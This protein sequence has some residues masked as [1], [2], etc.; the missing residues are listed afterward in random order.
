MWPLPGSN[1]I[2][3]AHKLRAELD[4]L[5][6]TLP[7]HIDMQLAFDATKFMEDAL[8][9][10]SHTLAETILIVGLVV[11]L[12]VGSIRTALVPLIAMPVSQ[13]GA[14]VLMLLLGF[15]LNLLTILAIVLSVGLVVDDAIV[16]V[17]NIQRHVQEGKS[18]TKAALI[19]ARE[20]V[21]PIIAMTITLAVVYAPIGFQ[22]GLTGMFVSRVCLY[23]G[24]SGDRV[25]LCGHHALAGDERQD[26]TCL[27]QRKLADKFVNARFETVRSIYAYC[28]EFALGLR[29]AIAFC[30]VL[31]AVAAA[32]LYMF[33]GKELAPVE[34]QSAIAVFMSGAPDA[35]LKST[36][37]WDQGSLLQVGGARGSQIHVGFGHAGIGV[38]R[39]HNQGLP[40]THAQ[41]N[42]YVSGSFRYGIHGARNQ[43]VSHPL[44]AITWGRSIRRGV[45]RQER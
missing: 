41:Y 36:T 11:F 15:S 1:E 39:H 33:S 30:T 38:W 43:S 25:R 22:G 14:T 16:V 26:G 24:S 13:I 32:P 18:R 9:E 3:V 31:I 5:R 34:D 8:T 12:F 42:G 19:G 2:E 20:L 28:L 21:G 10:I 27:G 7:G 17:E 4:K 45:G 37:K 35:T 40:R 23:I 6:P 29:W 44:A